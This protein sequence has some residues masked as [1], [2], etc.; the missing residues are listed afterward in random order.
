M[1][2]EI[3][4][5]CGSSLIL[6]T[7]RGGK[8]MKKC[9]TGGWDRETRKPI[10]CDYVDWMDKPQLLDEECPQCQSKL[11]LVTVASGRKLKKCSTAKWD[12]KTRTASGCT[13]VQWINDR[14][15]A[16]IV[17]QSKANGDESGPDFEF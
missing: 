1:L 16:A 3:C 4:P 2:E 9:S 15:S 17:A 10:G 7:T 13:Y 5:K 6:Q 12:R 14:V 11:V 8:K